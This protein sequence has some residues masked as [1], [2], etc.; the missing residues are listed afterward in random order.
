MNKQTVEKQQEYND[1]TRLQHILDIIKEGVWEWDAKSGKVQRSLGWYHMLGYD[2]QLFPESLLTWKNVIHP[3]DY[4]TVMQHFEDYTCGRIASY[5]I[6]YRCRK[7][8]GGFLWIRD[9]GKIVSRNEDG[10][11]AIMIGA[12]LDIHHLKLSKSALQ[13]QDEL[14]KDKF[15]LEQMVEKRTAELTELN[16]KLEENFKKIDHLKNIDFLTS[17][18]NRRK[19]EGE[20]SSEIAR[21]KR[22]GTLLSVAQFDLDEFK[23]INDTRG[24]QSGDLV[25]QGVSQLVMRHIRETDLLGRWGGDEFFIILPGVCLSDAVV[26]MEKLR[27]LIAESEFIESLKVTCSFGVTEYIEGDLINTLY[28]RTDIAL[29][30]AKNAGRNIV[31]HY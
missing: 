3:D 30:K 14:N 8:D 23:E 4:A 18:F 29:Y 12:H 1:T 13:L 2:K 19:L 22:Y 6:K 25:L 31:M 10:S 15:T 7:G 27:R 20:L 28:K 9:Q 5:D 17:V 26:S 11:V 24:H 21:S 16:L